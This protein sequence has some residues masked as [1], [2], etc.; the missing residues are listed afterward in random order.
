MPEL[1]LARYKVSSADKPTLL[2]LRKQRQEAVS[3][4]LHCALPD[5][6][7][8]CPLQQLPAHLCTSELRMCA[9]GGAGEII[10]QFCV[11]ASRLQLETETATLTAL[12]SDHQ[13]A[14]AA[15]HRLTQR[16]RAQEAA[17]AQHQPAVLI[18]RRQRAME[19]FEDANMQLVPVSG[20]HSSRRLCAGTGGRF[21]D[22]NVQL[23]VAA[24]H[25][26]RLTGTC[27][28]PVPSPVLCCAMLCPVQGTI[29]LVPQTTAHQRIPWPLDDRTTRQHHPQHYL[30]PLVMLGAVE[31]QDV[32]KAR[33]LPAPHEGMGLACCAHDFV[34]GC[35]HAG[36]ARPDAAA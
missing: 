24:V 1:P 17:L 7:V 4:G 25:R 15:V 11:S 16:V 13:A 18:Q 28:S 32:N 10:P 26:R 34:P 14:S 20:G 29:C 2:Q 33:P 21:E 9:A 35:W 23:A 19:R 5:G 22:A 8:A 27:C 31:R 12:R 30:G 6:H 3:H 36:A